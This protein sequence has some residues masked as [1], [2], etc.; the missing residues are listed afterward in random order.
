MQKGKYDLDNQYQC[1]IIGET[2]KIHLQ[3]LFDL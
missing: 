3:V 2:K 1:S